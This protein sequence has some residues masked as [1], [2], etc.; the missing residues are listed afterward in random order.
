MNQVKSIKEAGDLSGKRVLLRLALDVP[1]AFGKVLESFRLVSSF[2]T[3]DF[4]L[5]QGA[6]IVI[7]GHIQDNKTDL[8]VSL[9]P[10]CDFLRK[11]YKIEF[12]QKLEEVAVSLE[13]GNQIVM[14]ENLRFNPGEK[15][16]DLEFS[17][18]LASLAD[19]YVNEAFSVAHRKHASI[20]AVPKFLPSYA[21]L[22]FAE[23][24]KNLS[25][26]FNPPEKF[27]FI[28]GGAKVSTKLPLIKKFLPKT[29]Q[30]FI[31]GVLAND[32][33]KARGL[34]VGESMLSAE[35]VGLEEIFGDQ[36][37]V[38]PSDVTVSRGDGRVVV[39]PNEVEPA[40]KIM[41][42][43]GATVTLLQS[44]IREAELVIWNGP[45]GNYEYGFA[46][47]TEKV[48][49]LLANCQ[50]ETI[51]GGGDTVAVIDKLG[52]LEKFTFVSTGGGAMLDFL[53]N[54]TLPG[55]EALK[56]V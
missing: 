3:I 43:G 25:R 13:T 24:V 6:K 32:F 37:I 40:D 45:L 14:L 10:V 23:E 33:F 21:G 47:G 35:T 7:I 39:L 52:L 31:G 41:D 18:G 4:L 56:L 30:T 55:I 49:Q 1:I 46:A 34:E 42:I 19:I 5:G 15:S 17:K 28:L 20:V 48:A 2:P 12:V 50:A 44:L 26:A 29:R 9:Q 51:I 8:P 27:L 36:K 38:L 54:E 16:N 22:L 11:R 53:A